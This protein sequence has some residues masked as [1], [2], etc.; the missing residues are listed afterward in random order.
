M[1]FREINVENDYQVES[2]QNVIVALRIAVFYIDNVTPA[3]PSLE[4]LKDP[5]RFTCYEWVC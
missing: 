3:Y 1:S 5:S 2:A 4:V